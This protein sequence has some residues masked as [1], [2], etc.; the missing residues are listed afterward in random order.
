MA[1]APELKSI[2]RIVHSLDVPLPAGS[3]KINVYPLKH[4]NAEELLPV[5]ADLI[6]ARSAGGGGRN[7]I[8]AAR[9]EP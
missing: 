7:A 9:R 2:R 3:S 8:R 1:S 6:G 5:L 4:A